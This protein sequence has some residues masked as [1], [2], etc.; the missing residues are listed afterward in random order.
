M[1]LY[2]VSVA[3][4]IFILMIVGS[5]LIIH[6][7]F[8][9]RVS[10]R[11]P[12]E[13]IKGCPSWTHANYKDGDKGNG[14]ERAAAANLHQLAQGEEKRLEDGNNCSLSFQQKGDDCQAIPV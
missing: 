5:R 7:Y 9:H 4:A 10:T 12:G 8:C 3:A 6:F 11:Y 13:K 14:F 1:F 2:T